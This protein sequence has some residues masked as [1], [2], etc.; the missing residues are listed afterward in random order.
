MPVCNAGV[1]ENRLYRTLRAAVQI[2]LF[3]VVM[4]KKGE[5]HVQFKNNRRSALLREG[6]P[7]C[8]KHMVRATA[9]HPSAGALSCV[10]AASDVC[11]KQNGFV[12][13]V[14]LHMGLS[15]VVQ[16]TLPSLL[17]VRKGVWQVVMSVRHNW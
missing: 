11:E 1:N 16:H 8:L 2:G 9:V 10:P 6:H 4:P 13:P 14:M 3:E 5:E 15:P 7:N 12:R 17:A